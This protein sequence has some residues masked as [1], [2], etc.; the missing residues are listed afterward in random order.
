[1]QACGAVLRTQLAQRGGQRVDQAALDALGTD[2]EFALLP[3]RA[4]LH[5]DQL[6]D[7]RLDRHAGEACGEVFAPGHV[8]AA[9]RGL[10]RSDRH[11]GLRQPALPGAVGAQLRPAAAAQGQHHGGGLGRAFAVGRLETQARSVDADATVIH[12]QSQA[13]VAQA[14]YPAAQQR[15]GLHVGRKDASR[16]ALEGFDAESGR[17]GAQGFGVEIAQPGFERFARGTVAPEQAVEGFAVGQV[18]PALAGQQELATDRA[19]GFVEVHRNAGGEG[20]FGGHQTGRS[21]TD[22]GDAIVVRFTHGRAVCRLAARFSRLRHRAIAART[23]RARSASG[24][25]RCAMPR[26]SGNHGRRAPG[27]VWTT[28]TVA[29][30]GTG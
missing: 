14:P 18:E 16:A 10:Q 11:R 26:R 12:V 17:P 9:V 25:G 20:G 3:D 21:A 30:R 1:M 27:G 24:P 22:D 6:R 15:R 5:V 7:H 2:H 28:G 13:L 8:E 29:R 19:L 23:R 4:A